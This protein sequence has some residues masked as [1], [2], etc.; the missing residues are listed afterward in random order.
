MNSNILIQI[1]AIGLSTQ[2]NILKIIAMFKIFYLNR[3]F[4]LNTNWLDY[5]IA[6]LTSNLK[7]SIFIY[8]I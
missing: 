5:P 3:H 8:Y 2:K 1:I 4:F 6:I 7:S